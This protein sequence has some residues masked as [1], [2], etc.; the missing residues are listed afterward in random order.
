MKSVGHVVSHR[1]SIGC[2]FSSVW[3]VV[4]QHG[5]YYGFVH[6]FVVKFNSCH[7]AIVNILEVRTTHC[8]LLFIALCCY[9]G[10]F[11]LGHYI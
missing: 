7:V 6:C 9:Q 1:S 2:W 3:W 10:S 11:A 8:Y 5:M 4:R